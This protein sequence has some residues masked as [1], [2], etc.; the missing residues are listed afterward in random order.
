MISSRDDAKKKKAVK[1]DD[2]WRAAG[3]LTPMRDKGP[4]REPGG[5]ARLTL[6]TTTHPEN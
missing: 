1:S 2:S 3:V 5:G 6:G 4:R